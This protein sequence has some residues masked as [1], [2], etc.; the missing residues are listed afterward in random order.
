MKVKVGKRVYDSQKLPIMLVLTEAESEEI[1]KMPAGTHKYALFP[2]GF[3]DEKAMREWMQ[4]P[5]AGGKTL[6]T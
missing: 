5:E 1:A 3:G 2:A 6:V 4:L